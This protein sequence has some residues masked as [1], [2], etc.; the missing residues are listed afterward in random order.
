MKEY[1]RDSFWKIDKLVPKK[2][3]PMSTFSTGGKVV[4]YTVG[5][6]DAPADPERGRLTTLGAVGAE[7]KEDKV[8]EPSR[9]LIKRVTVKYT[10]DKFDFHAHF[11]KAARLYY[12]FEAPECEFATYYSYMPQYSH[13]NEAQK[14]Y[15]FYWR[16]ALRRGE[17]IKTDYSYL[18]L[19]VYEIINLPDLIPPKQGIDMLITLWERYRGQLP[20]IDTNM[21]LWVQDYCLVHGLEC[22]MDKLSGFIF[23]ILG[24]AQFKEFYLFDAENLEEEAIA[25]VL[26]YLSDYDWRTGRYAGGDNREAYARHMTGAMRL[27]ISHLH[28]C[29]RLLSGTEELQKMHRGAFK[30][31]LTTSAIKC[32]ITAEYIPIASEAALRATVTAAVKYTE[33]KLRALM[34]AKSRLAVKGLEDEYKRIIDTYFAELFDKVNRER[35]RAARPEYERL[36]EVEDRGLSAADADE[37]ERASWSTTARLVEDIDEYAEATE[38]T[39]VLPDNLKMPSAPEKGN[40]ERDIETYG[41]DGSHIEFVRAALVGDYKEMRDIANRLGELCDTLA[42]T[43]NGAFADGFGDVILEVSDGG[44]TVIEDY[45]EDIEEWIQSLTR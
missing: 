19:Y 35:A 5:G 42:D 27:L 43:V 7:K 34:G 13:M 2:K 33:N 12:D 37:I 45:K 25:P 40:E 9:G 23:S 1:D 21:S 10:P 39:T 28:S 30:Y 11:V 31:A 44:Y 29:G 8:Y 41:L 32:N 24:A 4:D 38:A 16:G 36:Y 3:T 6:E 17:F 14:S 22:P 15:Y 18:Y 26:A 20:N